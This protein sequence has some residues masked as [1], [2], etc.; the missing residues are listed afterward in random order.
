MSNE[1][2]DPNNIPPLGDSFTDK[3]LKAVEP[4]V[5]HHRHITHVI[6][7][8]LTAFFTYQ[9]L[10]VRPDAGFEKS[11]PQTHEFMKVRAKWRQ[12][13]GGGNK[14]MVAL[15]QQDGGEIYNEKTLTALKNLTDDIQFIRGVDRARTASL[16][17][18]STRYIEVVEGGLAG[19]D[20]VPRDYVP[21]EANFQRVR[22]N[23]GKAGIIGRLVTNSQ[24]GAMVA[25]EL[26]D[27]VP[28]DVPGE[29]EKLDLRQVAKDFEAL[30]RYQTVRDLKL[31]TGEVFEAQY[32]GA[33]AAPAV[34]AYIDSEVD[35][36]VESI[37]VAAPSGKVDA[38]TQ[39]LLTELGKSLD[40]NA[41]STV[42]ILGDEEAYIVKEGYELPNAVKIA[43]FDKRAEILDSITEKTYDDKDVKVHIIG[44]AK[45]IGDVTDA[46]MEVVMFFGIALIMTLVLL[47]LYT[48]SFKLSML[49]LGASV[50][51]VIWEFGLLHTFGFGLDPFAIL[52]PFLILS[53]SVSHGVQYANAWV[54]EMFSGRTPYNASLITFRRLA[55]PGTTALI[56]DLAGFLTIALIEIQIIQEMAFNATFGVFA[57]I[58][59]NKMLMPIWLTMIGVGDMDSFKV[60]QEK[61]DSMGD[62]MWR[63]MAKITRTVPAVI[64]LIIALGLTVWG[65]LEYPKLQVGD[66]QEG[67]PE[68]HAD[69]RYNI[70]SGHIVDNFAIG[71]DVLTV[72]AEVPQA[73]FEAAADK[74]VVA[75]KADGSLSDDDVDQF[76]AD[77]MTNY[78]PNSSY[79]IMSEIDRFIWRMENTVGVQSVFSLNKFAKQVNAGFNN[80]RLDAAILPRN[81]NALAQATTMVPT[82]TGLWNDKRNGYAIMIFTVDHKAQTI[83]DIVEA[84]KAF[85]STKETTKVNFALA[86]DNVGVMAAT[87]AEVKRLELQILAF[88]Y[89]VV[90]VFMYLSFGQVGG[91]LCVV[92]PLSLV[93]LLAYGVMVQFDIG[94]KVATLPVVALAV[95][96]GVDYGIYIYSTIQEGLW[97]DETLEEATYQTLRKTGKAVVFT[98]IT[99]GLG[100]FTWL[101]S[102]LKFQVDMGIMLI[103]MFTANMFGAILLLPALARFLAK[104]PTKKPAIAH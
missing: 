6:L 24:N 26:L 51:A 54:A 89:L 58:V 75:A 30:R 46:T 11:V 44:F 83:T 52:V 38:D 97:N 74:A 80:G 104:K 48:G 69:S 41:N 28:S 2:T 47:W 66:A 81:P 57:I 8:I 101:F 86:T 53:V 93:S 7:L 70:D 3:I 20:V 45:V 40:E 82:S 61:R 72:V 39:E 71:V 32:Q 90:L 29:Y 65:V 96:I 42:Y 64:T 1:N 31:P 19:A 34:A 68:L 94:M 73:V 14:M 99:L 12:Y 85:E 77:F 49:P 35:K 25:T 87:N 5:Y 22:Q 78:E 55:I 102:G 98:G 63:A 33:P 67:V 79:E 10:Q 95:G 60:K 43:K 4:V 56:T 88:V 27:K 59:T 17:T 36:W 50:V 37:S 62:G 21:N 100:V 23:T 16:F 13:F 18:P 15:I 91:V 84:V 9:T 92:L 76:R 103:F